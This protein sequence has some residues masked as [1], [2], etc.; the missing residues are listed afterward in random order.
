LLE[1]AVR[2][3]VERRVVLS[4]AP[5]AGDGDATAAREIR[6]GLQTE[7]RT[8]E[9]AGA[10]EAEA[11]RTAGYIA[12]YAT[13]STEVVG[14]LMHPLEAT[15]LPHLKMRPHARRLVECAWRLGGEAHLEQL[16]LRRWA[17]ALG[18]RGHCFTKSRRYSTTFT[19][20]RQAR[21][22]HQLRRQHGGEPRDAWGRPLSIGATVDRRQ[23]ALAGIGYRTLGDAWLAESGA[24]RKRE[25]RRVA[26]EELAAAP[27]E[28]MPQ[29]SKAVTKW[30]A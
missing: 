14:G 6:W 20:L 22:E 23:W 3:V 2:A 1:R 4:P 19:R 28:G 15:D 7:V 26:R 18:F 5:E 13:K 27:V 12:K 30:S 11:A 16:R 25:E 10:D 9:L 24:M 29:P 21:H 17:H 8:L